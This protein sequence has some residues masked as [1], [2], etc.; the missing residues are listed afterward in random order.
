MIR[1]HRLLLASFASFACIATCARA[2]CTL[3][4]DA[5]TQRILKQEGEC[6]TRIT[7]ASTFKIA[8]ALMGYDAGFL[9]SE[10]APV[11][12]YHPGDV[13]WSTAWLADTDPQ[14]WIR[15]SVVWYS[16]RVTAALG[17][18]RFQRY[19]TAF[20]YGNADV[21]G[22]PKRHD[23]LKFAWIDSSLRISPLEQLA[24]LERVVRRELPVSALAFDMTGR[25]TEL[26]DAGGWAL[27][28]K[29]GTGFPLLADG[30]SDHAHAYG[31][32]VGWAMKGPR[33][34]VFVRQIQ[35]RSL[36]DGPAGL[37]ARDVFVRALPALL[38][39]L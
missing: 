20:G 16:Q 13:D 10:H 34:L 38:A 32:F 29:T 18:P 8:I 28:G 26:P 39:G 36:Q 5:A 3:V 1:F 31:W 23:G 12:K 30:R 27:H 33:T 35:D 19:A 2:D 17:A 4:A 21:S 7:P 24:F 9:K 22:D 14:K 15:D 25:I 11:L 6:A 37:R